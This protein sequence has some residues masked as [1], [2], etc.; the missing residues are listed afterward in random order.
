M[1]FKKTMRALLA[2]LTLSVAAVAAHAQALKLGHITPP[3]HVWHQVSEKI[4]TDLATASGGKMKIAVSPLQ[5]LGN[6]AQ[7]INLMQSGAQQFGIFTVGGLSNRE[8][9]FLGWSLPYVFKD[10]AHATRAAKAPAAKEMLKRLEQHGLIGLG[11]T[12]A[13]MRHVLSV[14]PVASA[15][16]LANKKIRSFPSPVYNDWWNANGAAPTAMPLSEVAPSLTTKLLDAVDID[17]DALVGLK[18]HQQA[19]NLTLTGHMAFPAVIVVSKK[20]WDTRSQAER[21]MIAK[22][23]ADAEQWGYKTA[24]DADVSN[25]A[26]AKA[27][28]ANVV[29]ADIASFQAV[30]SKVRDQY[31]AKNPLIADFY[32]Q[33]KDL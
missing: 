33:A 18:F 30:G 31:V 13:G 22:V 3:T 8:E 9:S 5:K 21:D 29:K 15:K 17:L 16:D 28:G 7:M 27:D 10:V 4:S 6:E 20:W 12:F 26:K 2:G 24:I 14:Q 11:Y 25:L 19:P 32:K 23:V 1:Q